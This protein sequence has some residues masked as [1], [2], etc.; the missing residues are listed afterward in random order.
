M[1]SSRNN[2]ITRLIEWCTKQRNRLLTCEAHKNNN[3]FW[4]L[5]GVISPFTTLKF[6]A[7]AIVDGIIDAKRCALKY[8]FIEMFS[9]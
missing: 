1:K 6:P 2:N 4:S 9:F 5:S 3:Y 8:M 7:P